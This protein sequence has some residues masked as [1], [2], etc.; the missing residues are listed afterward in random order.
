MN[1]NEDYKRL[2]NY[3][4]KTRKY[5]HEAC[6]ELNIDFS[7]VDPTVLENQI[8]TC[9]HCGIWSTKLMPDLDLNPICS[10]C[11]KLIGL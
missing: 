6:N 10:T 4:Y 8:S 3:L 7:R 1:S 5:L 11:A 9:T 2:T